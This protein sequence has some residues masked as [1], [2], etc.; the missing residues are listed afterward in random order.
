M[1]KFVQETQGLDFVGA[2]EWLAE[3]FRIP[4]EYEESSPAEEARRRAAQA[5]L[6]A[7]RGR[8]E[9]LRAHAVGGSGRG[10]LPANTWSGAGLARRAAGSSGSGSRP[11]AAR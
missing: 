11:A 6:R 8:R 4:L 7:A 5:A 10:G 2:V 1:F 9:L 3:R